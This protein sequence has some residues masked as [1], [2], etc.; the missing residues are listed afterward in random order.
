MNSN[1]PNSTF[2]YEDQ[3]EIPSLPIDQ[4]LTR[5]LFMAAITSDKGPEDYRVV[6]EDQFFKLYGKSISFAKHGQP[7][8]QAAATINA[9]GSLF[10][11]RVVAEDA[12]LAHL[13]IVASV[14]PVTNEVDV[15]D[16]DG[17]QLYY[18]EGT[19]G[20]TT[21]EANNEDGEP[22]TKV[23][24]SVTVNNI[25]YNAVTMTNGAKTL[26]EIRSYFADQYLETEITETKDLLDADGN[27]LYYVEG[28]SGE[29]TTVESYENEAGETIIRTKATEVVP[30]GEKQYLLFIVAD[31]GRGVSKKN[32][33]ITADYA[34][35]KSVSYTRYMFNVIEDNADPESVQFAFYPNI[36]DNGVNTSLESRIKI[37]STQVQCI[38]FDDH[39]SEFIADLAEITGMSFEEIRDTDIMFG[40]TKKGINLPRLALSSEGISLSD[41]L[42][43]KGGSD[44]EF[45]NYAKV[46]DAPSYNDLMARVFYATALGPVY[47]N[48]I[49]DRESYKVDAIVD[50][51]Y[52]IEVQD[53][54]AKYTT[55]R[56]DCLYFRDLGT[57]LT[58]LEEI[59]AKYNTV[60]S[61]GNPV[62][63]KNK[64]IGTYCNS[65]DIIDP[66][67]RKQI[68][69]TIGYSIAKLLVTHI[70][71][72]RNRPFAGLLYDVVLHDA[73]DGTINFLPAQTPEKN[74]MEELAENKINYVSLHSNVPVI[75]TLYTSQEKHTQ[76]SYINNI[77][78]IQEVIKA[79]REK[80]PRIRYNF[81]EGEDLEKYKEDV[82]DV[83]ENYA[84]NF[85]SITLEYISDSVY[86]S[87]K[88]FYAAIK[89]QFKNFVQAEYFKVIALPS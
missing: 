60:D 26:S 71:N 22:R 85:M 83:I 86:I 29:T 10:V 33:Q 50:A 87:N 23:T 68:T 44:G 49:Y 37:N 69:V 72:G 51:N 1:Y 8:L 2:V 19:S 63:L 24:E 47:S 80:C 28:T 59:L 88:I 73:I 56:E 81:M 74:E 41:R 6:S 21:I 62:Y 25:S 11:K 13:A 67:S 70:N 39:I 16:A 52:P 27:Q 54:I 35:S 30:T 66:Y 17:N 77:L 45:G 12:T 4:P 38:Q 7:L 20:A 32:F 31:N 58:T 78:A 53:A 79:I 34:S 42:G 89:V 75:E 9:G 55:F 82:D 76:F 40:K 64:F 84:N 5:P 14:K 3:S 46:S 48:V 15:T 18:V 36:I 61:N 43:L 65:Y 57:G